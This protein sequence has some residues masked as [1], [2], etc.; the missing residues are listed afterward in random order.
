MHSRLGTRLFGI[1]GVAA[2]LLLAGASAAWAQD[3]PALDRGDT[4]WMLTATALVLMMTVPGLALFYAGMVRKMNALA[5]MM[6][7]FAICCLVTVLWMV[8]RLQPGLHRRQRRVR[9]L[10]PG[11]AGGLH[12]DRRQRARA[13]PSPNRST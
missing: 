5:T 1:G 13:R 2:A 11:A 12:P 6:Q 8:A 7:S 9:R 3:K 4:A 10:E